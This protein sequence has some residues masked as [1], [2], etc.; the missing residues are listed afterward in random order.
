VD[1]TWNS[2]TA[3]G[4]GSAA[5]SQVDASERARELAASSSGCRG[6]GGGPDG[7]VRRDLFVEKSAGYDASGSNPVP[8]GIY[9]VDASGVETVFA[10]V[11]FDELR[12]GPGGVWG[13]NL[14]VDG[15][16]Y[17]PMGPR[18]CS[19]RFFREFDWVSGRGSTARCS[20]TWRGGSG[21]IFRVKADGSRTVFATGLPGSIAGAAGLCGSR[22]RTAASW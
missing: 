16:I 2:A 13:S 11:R 20:P 4:G 12:F 17:A 22:T 19:A 5:V 15:L 21:T 18:R 10:P 7:R 1:V 14:F 8:A 3:Q 6:L 9:R